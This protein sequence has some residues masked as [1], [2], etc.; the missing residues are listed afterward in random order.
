M[1]DRKKIIVYG[2]GSQY[3]LFKDYIGCKF[4]IIGYSDSKK[5]IIVGDI[6]L[7]R[8]YLNINMT[9]FV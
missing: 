8:I 1:S 7:L 4:D 5:N 2:L 9:T 6:L 3:E